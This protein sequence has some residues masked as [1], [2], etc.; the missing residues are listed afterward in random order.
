[1]KRL[2]SA[3]TLG[4]VVLSTTP[5]T[6]AFTSQPVA[7]LLQ[8]TTSA[9]SSSLYE[10]NAGPFEVTVDLPGEGLAAQMKFK[11]VLDVPSKMVEVR[12]AVPFGLDVAPQNNL[13]ICTKDGVSII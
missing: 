5:S 4:L 6:Y 10:A 7:S 2:V 11:P 12:Y 13:A 3:T 9:S 8:R 1:M